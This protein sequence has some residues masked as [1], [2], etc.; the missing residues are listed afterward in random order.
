MGAMAIT[1]IFPDIC[2]DDLAASRDFYVALLELEVAWES[3][4]YVLLVVEGAPQIQLAFVARE[5]DS[6]PAAGRRHPS[7]VLITIDVDD[8]DAVHD[9]AH[10]NGVH[11]EQSLRNESFG[12]RH[13][14]ATDP[15]GLLVDVVQTLFVPDPNDA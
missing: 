4:W 5:H 3:D 2:T 8:V 9:R 13:F 15:N 10:A 1:S 12:Q 11:I 7:G 6:V 14:I